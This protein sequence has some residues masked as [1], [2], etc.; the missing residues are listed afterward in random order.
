MRYD[1]GMRGWAVGVLAGI[2]LSACARPDHPPRAEIAAV[3]PPGQRVMKLSYPAGPTGSWSLPLVRGRVAGEDVWM[4]VD[5]GANY[6]VVAGWLVKKTGLKT[7]PI[8]AAGTDHAGRP[9]TTYRVDN[10]RIDAEGWGPV[11]QGTVL[12]TDVPAVF[13]RA[14]IGVFLSPGQ[15]AGEGGGVVVDLLHDEVRE[16]RFADAA[17]EVAKHGVEIAGDGARVCEDKAGAMTGRSY[18]VSA[19]VEGQPVRLLLDTGAPRSDLSS[20]SPAGKALL[21]HAETAGEEIYTASGRVPVHT[22]VAADVAVGKLRTRL[23]VDVFP[24]RP[25]AVCPRDGALGLDVLHRCTMALSKTKAIV[26]CIP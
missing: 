2:A 7:R 4:L 11:A 9:I 19:R 14:H 25:D 18:V 12:G 26:R 21:P 3:A 5:T 13:E 24:G 10:A 16:E 1:R 23:D 22:L 20:A 15:L 6:H 17:R 8:G